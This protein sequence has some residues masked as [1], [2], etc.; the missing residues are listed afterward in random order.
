MYG[1]GFGHGFD[2]HL[3]DYVLCAGYV[4][5][6]GEAKICEFSRN[7]ELRFAAWEALLRDEARSTFDPDGTISANA[8]QERQRLIQAV[9]DLGSKEA[10][11]RNHWGEEKM[12]KE[13]LSPYESVQQIQDFIKR[14]DGS[15]RGCES[16]L[17]E[18]LSTLAA[19]QPYAGLTCDAVWRVYQKSVRAE[20]DAPAN[21]AARREFK[22]RQA[23]DTL[24]VESPLDRE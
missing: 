21:A 10:T 7:P 12:R 15:S 9:I 17:R 13:L 6:M 3:P 8:A 1:T 2:G 4:P 24:Y 14:F 5:L 18:A 19:L 23:F 11:A 22:H 20:F 16:V